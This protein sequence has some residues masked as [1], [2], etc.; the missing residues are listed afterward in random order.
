MMDAYGLV[1]PA[2]DF[3]SGGAGS[4]SQSELMVSRGSEAARWAV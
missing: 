3:D 4:L 2:K 1:H